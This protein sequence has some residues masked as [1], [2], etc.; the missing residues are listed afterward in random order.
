M[1]R[2]TTIIGETA[3]RR[4]LVAV[5]CL[6][7]CRSANEPPTLPS[8]ATATD[9]FWAL[10]DSSRAV[11]GCERQAAWLV[12]ALRTRTEPELREFTTELRRRLAESYRWDLW[13]V[14]Y[15]ANGGA[16]DDGF[17]YFRG[18]LITQ[19]RRRYERALRIRRPQSMTRAFGGRWNARRCL[20][21]RTRCTTPRLARI[22]PHSILLTLPSR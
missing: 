8:H 9:R 21:C 17:E 19:G 14:A 12:S 16:S 13:A 2:Q 5:A 4:L 22:R 6:I 18:W 15:V 10:I 20:A 1:G 3:I 11:S 7:G